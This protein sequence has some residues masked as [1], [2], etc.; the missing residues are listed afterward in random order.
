MESS[1]KKVAIVTVLCSLLV[2]SVIGLR[3]WSYGNRVL[4]SLYFEEIEQGCYCGI[5]TRAE[6]VI[7]NNESWGLLWT[8]LHNISTGV[9]NLPSVNFTIEVVFAVFLGEF[10]TGGYT[11]EITRIAP[12]ANRLTIYIRETHPGA[13]CGTTQALTQPYHIVKANVTSW[14]SF[15]FDYTLVI[16]NCP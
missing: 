12:I 11:A 13:G 8:D 15:A 9:P 16:Q 3:G 10:N 7:E 2:V 4:P 14:Q 5:K 1:I 6:Y